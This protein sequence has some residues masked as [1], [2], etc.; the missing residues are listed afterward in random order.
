MSRRSKGPYLVG[1]EAFS[2]K[3]DAEAF[4]QSILNRNPLGQELLGDDLTFVLALLALHPKAA[5]KVG[6]GV[7]GIRVVQEATWGTRHFELVRTDG[8]TTDFSFMKCLYPATKLQ[9]FRQACRHAVA[10]DIIEFRHRAF[11]TA[12]DAGQLRCPVLDIPMTLQETH[13]DHEPPRTFDQLVQEFIQRERIEVDA[14]ALTGLGD[15]ELR[16][17][18]ANSE[19][20][21]RWREFHRTNARLRVVSTKANLSAIRRTCRNSATA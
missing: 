4:V 17:G 12:N 3:K 8:S 13:V 18:L 10:D 16:K 11:D 20:E 19:L 9:L 6:T 14:V 5:E 21:E 7:A 2:T 15:G 1:S